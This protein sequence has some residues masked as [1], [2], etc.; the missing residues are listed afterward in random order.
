LPAFD[1][2][3]SHAKLYERNPEAAKVLK[4]ILRIILLL[5][6]NY[7]IFSSAAASN[8]AAQAGCKHVHTA[9]ATETS[10]PLKNTSWKLNAAAT[11]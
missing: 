6:K 8:C 9:G 4:G 2:Y 5:S 7:S 3:G 11:R 1:A 10:K